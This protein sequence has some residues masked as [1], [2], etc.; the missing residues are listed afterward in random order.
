MAMKRPAAARQAD[1]PM[2]RPVQGQAKPKLEKPSGSSSSSAMN[3]PAAAQP[4]QGKDVVQSGRKVKRQDE[5]KAVAKPRL[6]APPPASSQGSGPQERRMHL[7][8]GTGG[9]PCVFS[10]QSTGA[11]ARYQD[12]SCQ[13]PWCNDAVLQTAL[14]SSKGRG[15]L[16]RSLKFFWANNKEI[17]HQARQRLPDA[18]RAY[19]PLQALGFPQ[20]FH[21]EAAMQKATSTPQGLGRVVAALRKRQN[22]D[23]PEVEEAFKA[24]PEQ[25]QETLRDK[26]AQAP[27][28]VRQ[29]R[30][31]Q[32]VE[33]PEEKWK[34]LLRHRQRLRIPVD[35]KKEEEDYQ[36]WL[37]EDRG[38]VQKKFFP[39][40][41]REVKHTGRHWTNPLSEELAASVRDLADND[42]GLPRADVSPMAT[43]LE[44]WCKTGSWNIC[45]TCYS[46]E[47]RHLKEV[48]TRRVATPS[49]TPC[50]WCSKDGAASVPTVQDVPKKLRYLTQKIVEALR[51]LEIDCGP[52]KRPVHGYRE[53]TAMVRL[54]WAK[55]SV[56]EK[57]SAL[58]KKP[59]KK[60]E[61]A[62]EY[63]MKSEVSEY[64]TFVSSHNEFLKRHPE[65]AS[66]ADRR[67]PLQQIEAP[68]VECAL[69]PDLYFNS[70]LCETVERATDARRLERQGLSAAIWDNEED[71][72]EEGQTRG[73]IRRSFLK[74]ALGPILDYSADFELFQFVHDLAYWSELGAKRHVQPHL[75]MRVLMKGAPFTPA[76][77]AVRHAAV[78]DLQRQCGHPVMFKTWAPYEWSAPYHRALLHQMESLL[79]SRTHL[80]TLET[81]H[82]AHILVEL[83][84]EWVVGGARKQGDSSVAW[85]HNYLEGTPEDGN[86]R[87]CRINFAA[88]LEYQDGKRKQ[89]TQDYHGRGAIH[90]H[91]VIFAEDLACLNLPEKLFATEPPEDHPLR[92]YV[93]DQLSYSGSGWPVFEEPSRWNPTK[94]AIQLEHS[95]RDHD[96]GVRAYGLE[97]LDVL[98]C[99][100]DNIAPQ[101]RPESQQGLILRYVSTYN[102]KPSSE[103]HN[104]LLG[105]TN[106]SGYGLALRVLMCLHPSEPEMVM[107]LFKQLFPDFAM[108]GTM[109]PIVAPWPTMEPFPKFVQLYQ[110]SAWRGDNMTLLEFLRKSNDAGDVISWLQKAYEAAD[111]ALDLGEFATAYSTFGEKIIAAEMVSVFNDKYFGQWLMLNMPFRNAVDFLNPEVMAKVPP[112]YQMFACA[113]QAAPS[114]WNSPAKIRDQL[115]LEAKRTA[116]IDNALAMIDAQKAIV[117]QYLSGKLSLA[118]EIPE[119]DISKPTSRVADLKRPRFNRGQ[120]LLESYALERLDMVEALYA[121]ENKPEEF[122]AAASKLEE[123]NRP[124]LCL[125][126]PGTGKT[127]VA[128]YLIGLAVR[129]GFKVC[130]ALPTGALACRMRQKHTDICIDTCHGAFLFF[131]PLSEAI[132]SMMEYDMVVIDEVVQL[133]AEHFGRITAMFKEASKSLLL[134]L[135]GDDWQLPSIAPDSSADHP[136]WRLCQQITLTEVIRC[137][138]K[139]LQAKLD[140]LRYYKPMGQEGKRFV[141]NLCYEHKAWTGHHKPTNLDID[142]VLK[143]TN[144][145]TTFLTCTGRGAAIIN[146]LCVLVLFHNRNKRLLCKLPGDYRD[147]QE[148][149]T[150]R[151]A[152]RTDRTLV[153]SDVPIYV[154]L[155]IVLT[156]NIDKENHFV[157]GMV[158]TV[159]AFDQRRRSLMVMTE[160]N[161]R[162]AVYPFTDT[163]VPKGHQKSMVYYPIRIGYAG[164]VYKYQGA[165]LPHVTLWL[166]RPHTRAA[167]YVALSRVARDEHYLIGGIVTG[168]YLVP[169]K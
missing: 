131:R 98:K 88:R 66:E 89:A 2:K 147:N 27:R 152:L 54:L 138:C 94:E 5:A 14:A 110:D 37:A 96:Q 123:L 124:L 108:G 67:R 92:G 80:A 103:F 7:C 132:A 56:P 128:D 162:L 150:G 81:L 60:A 155:R 120:A 143:K 23:S 160:S 9:L 47:P 117:E 17:F 65:G 101:A 102:V 140:F 149:Y 104:E 34:R 76:Y 10:I 135:M 30:V 134:L 129:K 62:Y 8:R 133:S 12:A 145:K 71:D 164:T 118:D 68:G 20:S 55:Q 78:L 119:P 130:Y 43:M 154:G 16:N 39:E 91:A 35:A 167:A 90:L 49:I 3:R 40:R 64:K 15:R 85:R 161:R 63:L 105:D 95:E 26:L 99:H 107:S 127:F 146:A 93:L 111:T 46:L 136:H 82:L 159:E 6:E 142:Y 24:I 144:G 97:E 25:F 115:E 50:R 84:R 83:L 141:N 45:S 72:D 109:K 44:D 31:R 22:A 165:T 77:W 168:D 18:I 21:S 79:R 151:S 29:A 126:G 112:R 28:R 73:S 114:H 41:P 75:P 59:K 169:A 156:R 19:W 33:S 48:D 122:D 52:Y 166:D 53:H 113:L 100:V 158:C 11:P 4:A 86:G 74:K 139:V 106:I 148:N 42:T 70:N 38:R 163:D 116:Y 137:T 121:A 69:W 58:P 36:T 61:K 13:C 1:A 32:E 153:P 157:N 57:I 125:G 87:R 51:P